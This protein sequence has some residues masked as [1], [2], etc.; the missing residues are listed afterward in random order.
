MNK[1]RPIFK[2][3]GGKYNCIEQV[4]Q[5]LPD[6]Q[7][8]IE[9]FTGAATVFFNTTYQ[10]Y[11]LA[12]Q[13][14]DLILFYNMLQKHKL[15]FIE[16]CKRLFTPKANESKIY[17]ERREVFNA[18]RN[19]R[20]RA[21][22]FLYLNRHGYNGLCRYNR[23]GG[24]NVPFG[25]YKRVFFPNTALEQFLQKEAHAEFHHADF[26]ETFRQAKKGDIIYCDP[27]YVP[28]NAQDKG[29]NY[30]KDGFNLDDQSDLA[31]LALETAQKGVP[32][33]ISNHDTSIT[34]DL[35]AQASISSFP[36]TRVISCIGNKRKPVHEL[37]AVFTPSKEGYKIGNAT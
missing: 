35:Y 27:P 4:V 33:I 20:K 5:T 11:W 18:S 36:V 34:R 24:F 29:F 3:A 6:A 9:P 37:I 30:H 25:H 17:Y 32:V 1:V 13:N 2:W 12:E 19:G 22:L 14:S 8:L 10:N 31:T 21:A 16:Q 26:R 7:R 15:S 28:V 23:H